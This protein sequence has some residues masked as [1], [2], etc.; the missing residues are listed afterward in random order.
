MFWKKD[1]EKMKELEE[2]IQRLDNKMEYY[3]CLSEQ[4]RIINN[5]LLKILGLKITNH[6]AGSD[7]FEELKKD[8]ELLHE[9]SCW[10]LWAKRKK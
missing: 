4:Q 2:E 9:Q 6:Y 5:E 7:K 1:K 3:C 10:Q 8:N